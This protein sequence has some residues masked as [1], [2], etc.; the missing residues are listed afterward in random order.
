MARSKKSLE[1]HWLQGSAPQ[2]A[3]PDAQPYPAGKPKM[4]RDLSPV[5]QAEWKRL[6]RELQ[7]RGTLTRC[8]SSALEIYATTFARWKQAV[9]EVE[10]HGPV[11]ESTW[12]DGS[13]TVHTKRVENPA[14]KI[15]GRLENSLRAML[16]EFSATPASREKAKPA[17]PP[18]PGPN[19]C[20][21]P[22]G[23]MGWIE[24]MKAKGAHA[25]QEPT[26]GSV[27]QASISEQATDF[28]V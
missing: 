8:D 10:K 11:I 3:M 23:S 12:T 19:E 28:E 4:P 7:G 21:W 17:A 26:P 5:A 9:A 1:Q 22:E 13:G 2:W 24:W 25:P 16:K 14:S 20:P 6:V 18:E 27:A 15:A